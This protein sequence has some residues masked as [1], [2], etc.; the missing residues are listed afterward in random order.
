MP[1]RLK[2][3]IPLFIT[4]VVVGLVGGVILRTLYVDNSSLSKESSG[5]INGAFVQEEIKREVLKAEESSL[6]ENFPE[7]F[8]VYEG[9]KLT[10][11]WTEEGGERQGMSVVWET[12]DRLDSVFEFYKFKLESLGWKTNVVLE[13]KDSYTLSFEKEEAAGF[14]GITKDLEVAKTIISAT[15]G[16]R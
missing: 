2:F 15:I 4:V 7:A 10:D 13:S 11:S 6:P 8:P 5:S 12:N 14:M 16:I 9:V 3:L 1:K